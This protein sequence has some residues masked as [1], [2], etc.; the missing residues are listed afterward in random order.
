M[1]K[2][3]DFYYKYGSFLGIA[4]GLFVII[5]SQRLSTGGIETVPFIDRHTGRQTPFPTSEGVWIGVVIIL[6]SIK[7]HW[8][9]KLYYFI[10]KRR[11]KAASKDK[12]L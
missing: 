3:R 10:F 7:R 8:F 5:S 9:A 6:L 1:N 2:I 11:T 4:L 12:K